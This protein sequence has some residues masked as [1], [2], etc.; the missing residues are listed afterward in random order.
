MVHLLQPQ[1]PIGPP[2][3]GHSVLLHVDLE[4]SRGA[5]RLGLGG[6]GRGGPL[7][8]DIGSSRQCLCAG[9]GLQASR[10]SGWEKNN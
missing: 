8:F 4:G 10:K 3:R 1:T 7:L 5:L 2:G 6:E 9:G